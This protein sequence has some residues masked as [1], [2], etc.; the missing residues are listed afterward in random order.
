M[1]DA[2][3]EAVCSSQQGLEAR[4]KMGGIDLKTR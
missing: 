2:I 3:E 1:V 4:S